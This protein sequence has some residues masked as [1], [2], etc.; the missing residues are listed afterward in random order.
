MPATSNSLVRET[1]VLPDVPRRTYAALIEALGAHRQRH[2]YAHGDLELWRLVNS[3]SPDEYRRFLEATAEYALRHS[4]DG[5]TLEMM[6][7]RKDH[8]WVKCFIGRI[9]EAVAFDRDIEIQCIGS[10]TL[11]GVDFAQGLQPDEAYYIANE[12]RVRGKD[13]YEPE[14]DPP[15]D[16]VL[17]VDVTNS[18]IPRLPL[19]ARLGVPEVWRHDGSGVRFLRLAESGDYQPIDHSLAFPFLSAE[20]VNRCVAERRDRSE[21]AILRSLL[22]SLPPEA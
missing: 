21:N 4:F 3:V 14:V 1:V 9:I 7:P 19:L 8:D 10:T 2:T 17:E 16:L 18:S 20:A 22:A 5:W 15:P 12:P 6:S 13:E 11:R